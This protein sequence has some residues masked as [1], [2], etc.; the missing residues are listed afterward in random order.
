[1]AK[2]MLM[3]TILITLIPLLSFSKVEELSP[4]AVYTITGEQLLAIAN[5]IQTL[6][7]TISQ[8]SDENQ[9]LKSQLE[10]QQR[11]NNEFQRETK[12]NAI[13]WQVT[14]WTLIASVIAN[15]FFIY[16]FVMGG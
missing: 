9:K 12:R 10:E 2:R 14:I 7:N 6:E 5:K 4:N 15:L 8:L 16:K 13:I 1:M 11:V 3:L